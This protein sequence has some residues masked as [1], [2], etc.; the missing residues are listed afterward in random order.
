MSVET[1]NYLVEKLADMIGDGKVESPEG[2]D[3]DFNWEEDNR[4]SLFEKACNS[5]SVNGGFILRNFVPEYEVQCLRLKLES[6]L[7]G[8]KVASHIANRTDY[9]TEDYFLNCTFENIP[10]GMKANPTTLFNYGRPIINVRSG[11]IG[12][13]GDEGLVDIFRADPLFPEC[14]KTFNNKERKNFIIN[15]LRTASGKPYVSRLF[16][17]Y[18][19]R[20][21]SETRGFHADGFGDKVKAFLYLDDVASP[22]DGPYC[23]ARGTHDNLA[24]RKC[25]I[26][27]AKRLGQ[28]NGSNYNFWDRKREVKFLGKAGDFAI[29]FQRCAHRGWPQEPGHHRYALVETFMPEGMDP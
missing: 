1:I 23:F 6:L 15:V 21:I 2:T 8:K 27:I 13:P 9:E 7:A 3:Y 12:P 10:G 24:I 17:I 18:V 22:E 4:D 20:S 29:T 25:N 19:N 28:S 16:N 11:Q 26:D 5:M 14:H